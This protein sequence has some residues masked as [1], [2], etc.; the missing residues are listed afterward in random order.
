MSGHMTRMSLGC[1]VGSS[2]SSPTSTSRSTSTC[3][4]GPWQACTW[5]LSS[6]GAS[7]RR[8]SSAAVAGRRRQS[9][10][11]GRRATCPSAVHRQ[12]VVHR[13]GHARA[14]TAVPGRPGRARTA[15]RVRRRS[16]S[17]RAG[18]GAAAPAATARSGSR[19]SARDGAAT[20]G[21]RGARRGRQHL[22]LPGRKPVMPNS[23]SRCGR[24][25]LLG[26]AAE[27]S[28]RRRAGSTGSVNLESVTS[29]P[30][31][32]PARGAGAT[33][34]A[35]TPR[36]PAIGVPIRRPRTPAAQR[37]AWPAGGWRSRRRGRRAGGPP[38]TGGRGDML[39]GGRHPVAEV[40]GQ[41]AAPRL[42]DRRVDDLQ[43]RPDQA[44]RRPRIVPVGARHRGDHGTGC[45]KLDAGADAVGPAVPAT[46]VMRHPLG[47]PAF[48]A[49]G[50]TAT[51]SC[52]E[53][54]V[55][56]VGQQ[57]GQPEHQAVG[58]LRCKV[59]RIEASGR[60]VLLESRRR[61][62]ADLVEVRDIWP[63]SCSSGD[64][65]D[66]NQASRISASTAS[67]VTRNDSATTLASFQPTAP[68]AVCAS[69]QQ[70]GPD[71]RNLVGS[72][73][74][75]GAGPAAHQRLV[76]PAV[77]RLVAAAS[78]PMPSPVRH[79]RPTR[80]AGSACDLRRAT[81]QGP[82]GRPRCPR[83]RKRRFAW[84][85]TVLG[86]LQMVPNSGRACRGGSA[87][88]PAPVEF[89]RSAR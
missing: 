4:A 30:A 34:R 44:V 23:E 64:A 83:R 57:L 41:G 21:R 3:R 5:M 86:P 8:F 6:P 46:Q 12:V 88:T 15:A 7:T 82:P 65:A 40:G 37:R 61:S 19:A 75:A 14:P 66:S 16:P 29:G 25:T 71:A 60:I 89:G 22:Q 51:T 58:P 76:G 43:Q 13:A 31:N 38:R 10:A 17:G 67:E 49:A 36:R 33:A 11:A 32:L 42:A 69:P 9:R 62:V 18:G 28:R 48:D 54:V 87:A 70:R 80:R 73:A 77:R 52:G 53:H 78:A 27:L 63:G 59:R 39:V 35:A 84:R 72:D 2:A 85:P 24:S 68:A 79:R 26:S 1:R 56:R 45:G 47:Q 74:G 81:D 20:G 50:G 55:Q